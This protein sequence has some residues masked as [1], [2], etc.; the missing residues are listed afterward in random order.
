MLPV[1][2]LLHF[3]IELLETLNGLFQ[4]SKQGKCNTEIQ[5]VIG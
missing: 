3:D 4:K 1:D 2:I 5:Q